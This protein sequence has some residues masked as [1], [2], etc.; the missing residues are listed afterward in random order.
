[1]GRAGAGLLSQESVRGSLGGTFP[2]HQLR[3]ELGAR[4]L[5]VTNTNTQ[6]KVDRILWLV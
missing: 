2:S 1:M 6:M 3:P 5:V 4:L